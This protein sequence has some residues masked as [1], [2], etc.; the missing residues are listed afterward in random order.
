MFAIKKNKEIVLSVDIIKRMDVLRV[1][2]HMPLSNPAPN[3]PM[4]LRHVPPFFPSAAATFLL[5]E[6]IGFN[7]TLLQ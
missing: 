4:P 1:Q 6:V 2:F 3:K 5:K 7:S